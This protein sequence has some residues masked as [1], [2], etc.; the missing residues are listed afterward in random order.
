MPLH[1]QTASVVNLARVRLGEIDL[2]REY[3]SIRSDT[4]KL[5]LETLIDLGTPD[6]NVRVAEHGQRSITS[7]MDSLKQMGGQNG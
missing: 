6:E 3:H 5:L 4:L 7:L 1:N 2:S